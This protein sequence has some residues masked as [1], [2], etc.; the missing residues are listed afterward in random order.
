MSW[1]PITLQNSWGAYGGGYAPPSYYVDA[2][3]RLYCRGLIQAG[4]VT[5]GTALFTLPF[6]PSYRVL[7]IAQAYSGSAYAPARLDVLTTGVVEVFDASGF[8][9]S[10]WIS[11]DQ[12]SCSLIQ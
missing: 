2:S 12:V 6:T 4:I 11:L 3:G 7:T 1:Q 9:G 8:S 5:D 10:G